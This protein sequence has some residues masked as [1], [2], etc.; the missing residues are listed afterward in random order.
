MPSGRDSF[1]R[2]RVAPFVLF[3]F[4]TSGTMLG[5]RPF[6]APSIV[7]LG[8]DR[9]GYLF[10]RGD[11]NRLVAQLA[12]HSDVLRYEPSG[13]SL[14]LESVHAFPHD[15]FGDTKQNTKR[16]YKSIPARDKLDTALRRV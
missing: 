11:P 14:L 9:F 4:I 10:N 12:V 8:T 16:K 7:S 3:Y 6:S 13:G 5:R 2:N 1:R 15:P